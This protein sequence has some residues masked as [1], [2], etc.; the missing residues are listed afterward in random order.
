[1]Y[2]SLICGGLLLCCLIMFPL[3]EDAATSTPHIVKLNL[4]LFLSLKVPP[5]LIALRL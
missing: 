1:M 2:A 4:A 3:T 5:Y